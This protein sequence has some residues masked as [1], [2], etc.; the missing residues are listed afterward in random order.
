MIKVKETKT[1]HMLGDKEKSL[2]MHSRG[3]EKHTKDSVTQY[4]KK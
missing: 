4:T 3:R 2:R 1:F